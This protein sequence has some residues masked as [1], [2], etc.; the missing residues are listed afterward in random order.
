M[1]N[2]NNKNRK[3]KMKPFIT[4]IVDFDASKNGIDPDERKTKVTVWT[5]V[6]FMLGLSMLVPVGLVLFG[7]TSGLLRLVFDI[8]TGRF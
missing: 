6:K 4:P 5:F 2:E 8:I 3:D 7:I 1:S